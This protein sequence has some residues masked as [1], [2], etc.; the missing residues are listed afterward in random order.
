MLLNFM[1]I[2]FLYELTLVF[3]PKQNLGTLTI[4]YTDSVY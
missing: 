4:E 3:Q 2:H 1:H